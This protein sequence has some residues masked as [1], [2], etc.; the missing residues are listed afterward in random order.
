DYIQQSQQQ[1][2]ELDKQGQ[3]DKNPSSKV[4]S[5][6]RSHSS[7]STESNRFDAVHAVNTP[8]Y[9]PGGDILPI[10]V[11]SSDSSMSPSNGDPYN[12]TIY[13]V[14]QMNTPEMCDSACQTRESLFAVQGY[15]SENSTPSHS[16]H[17]DSPP[18]PFSTF[19]YK[20]DHRF[21]AEANIEMAPTKKPS[22]FE[23]RGRPYSVQ[24]TKSAPDVIVTH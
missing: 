15:S 9:V 13:T 14:D 19:G 18:A 4:G 21:K 5:R 11:R 20:K 8:C 12:T 24:T 10:L 7:P 23:D 1:L 17:A 22:K 2:N 3:I 6:S 16:A